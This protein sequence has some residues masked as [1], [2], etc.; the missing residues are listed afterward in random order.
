MPISKSLSKNQELLDLMKS[1]NEHLEG[2]CAAHSRSIDQAIKCGKALQAAKDIVDHGKWGK[3]VR[4]NFNGSDR[5]AQRYTRVYRAVA[6]GD[7]KNNYETLFELEADIPKEQSHR[8]QAPT[9]PGVEAELP[10][11]PPSAPK[12]SKKKDVDPLR[13]ALKAIG[14]A[15]PSVEGEKKAEWGRLLHAEI[16]L[17][18]GPFEVEPK[19]SRKAAAEKPAK[20][21]EALKS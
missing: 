5:T 16:D 9:N 19:R 13:D 14:K 18:M 12:P 3:F 8:E 11:E 6:S 17:Y 10:G 2:V 4:D 15:M 21:A 7:L 20:M 1:A